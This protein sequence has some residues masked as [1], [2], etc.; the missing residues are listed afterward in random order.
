MNWGLMSDFERI[1]T[2]YTFYVDGNRQNEPVKL[3][4]NEAL[5]FAQALC[6]EYPNS[7]IEIWAA[8]RDEA[9]S[10]ID[11]ECVR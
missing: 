3:H 6:E 5:R 4:R 8:N 10:K 2:V 9:D 1:S 7:N 11:F